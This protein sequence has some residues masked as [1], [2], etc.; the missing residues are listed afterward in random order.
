MRQ[1]RA[2]RDV[3]ESMKVEPKAH[4]LNERAVSQIGSSMGNHATER[5]EP[6]TKAVERMHKGR[7]FQAPHDAGRTIHQ[8][9]SQRRS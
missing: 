5:S 9:G 2:G 4:A 3:R 1:G 7:G 8:G 6:L